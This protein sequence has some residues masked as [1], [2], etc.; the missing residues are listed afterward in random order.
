MISGVERWRGPDTVAGAEAVQGELAARVEIPAGPVPPPR[1]VAGLDVSYRKDS[2]LVAAAAVVVDTRTLEVV[3]E[4]VVEGAAT[5]PYVPGLLAFREVPMLLR[6]LD[7]LTTPVDLLLCDGQGL[8]HPRRCGVACHLGVLTG[9]PAVGCAKNH[10][11]G[12]HDEPGPRRGDRSALVDGGDVLGCAL[13]TQDG[14]RPVYVSPGHRIGVD[15][16]GDVVLGLCGTFRLPD[17]VRRA[18]H[19]SRRALT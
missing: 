2:D 12:E 3:E 14:V 15:Q 9:L 5:F 4:A 18:D 1:R 7:A 13:R 11:V 6:A 10:L 8:A 16:A 17:P 19:I